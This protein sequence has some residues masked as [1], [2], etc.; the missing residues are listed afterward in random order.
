V[1]GKRDLWTKYFVFSADVYN[2]VH[3]MPSHILLARST[4]LEGWAVPCN[5]EP[6]SDSLQCAARNTVHVT[7]RL[8][9]PQKPKDR[10]RAR[11]S[12]FSDER[13]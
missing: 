10:D 5:I 4:D 6:C 2:L 7:E 1:N 12:R 11:T 9:L 8:W 13:G 3:Q